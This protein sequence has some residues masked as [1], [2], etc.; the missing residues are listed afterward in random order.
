MAA[1]LDWFLI[2]KL[3]EPLKQPFSIAVRALLNQSPDESHWAHSWAR[4]KPTD[5]DSGREVRNL[6][7]QNLP[8]VFHARVVASHS[9]QHP[10]KLVK[11]GQGTAESKAVNQV[12]AFCQQQSVSFS[13]KAPIITRS[14][15]AWEKGQWELR[16]DFNHDMAPGCQRE[17]YLGPQGV[18]RGKQERTDRPCC[19]WGSLHPV[20]QLFST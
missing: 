8:G 7:F 6:D 11:S 20:V 15:L 12:A 13:T 19:D 4:A 14:P 17:A 16:N 5:S 3:D 9:L 1:E 18:V 2:P 10:G